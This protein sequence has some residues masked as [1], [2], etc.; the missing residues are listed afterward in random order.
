M[1]LQPLDIRLS[2]Q[3]VHKHD[4]V[5]DLRTAARAHTELRL[6]PEGNPV[7]RISSSPP[8]VARA[9]EPRMHTMTG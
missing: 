1:L 7:A 5:S 8:F 9:A 3:P 6:I 4:S 2:G